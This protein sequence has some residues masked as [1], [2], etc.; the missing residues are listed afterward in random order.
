MATKKAR[1]KRGRVPS[2]RRIAQPADVRKAIAQGRRRGKEVL[3]VRAHQRK[4]RVRAVVVAARAQAVSPSTVPRIRPQ[5]IAELGPP[6]AAGVLIAEGDSWF[7]YPLH[8]VLTMLEDKHGFEVE[9]VAHRGDR[10]ENMAFADGQ[11]EEFSRRLEKVLRSGA[12]PRAILLSGGGNDVA[13]DQFGM[14]LNHAASPIAG[15]NDDIV[16]GIIDKRVKTAFL[17]IVSAITAIS[18]HYLSDPVP[19]ITHGYAHPVPD[20]RGFLGGFWFL[21]GPWL[22]PGFQEKGFEDL[23]RNTL[24]IQD[25]IDRFNRMVKSAA[26]QFA[27]VHYVDLRQTLSNDSRYKTFW[28]N[29]LHPTKTG[30]SL[31]ADAFA[32]VIGALP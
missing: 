23:R 29:E 8:D 26:A 32:S 15:L 11:L 28:A 21:P 18:D 16:T 22:K 31:V 4:Q 13:G 9:S 17:A 2:A 19:I 20:G 25:L 10:I 30:F 27:H 24:I 3:A 6:S 1:S 5:I 12:V 7:D 14:L